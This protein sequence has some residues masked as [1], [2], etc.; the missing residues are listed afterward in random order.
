M[1]YEEAVQTRA[2]CRNAGMGNGLT[3]RGDKNGVGWYINPDNGS[4]TRVPDGDI[5]RTRLD[6]VYA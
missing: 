2:K 1:T 4:I 3:M 5:M 6:W